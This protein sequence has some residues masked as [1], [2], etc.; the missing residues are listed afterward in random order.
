[1]KAYSKTQLEKKAEKHFKTFHEDSKA[2][3]TSDGYFFRSE[4]RAG[5]H[6]KTKKTLVVYIF[7]RKTE[8]SQID[9]GEAYKTVKDIEELVAQTEDAATLE[10]LL[11]AE[12]EGSNRKTAIAAIQARIDELKQK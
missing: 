3:A 6:A 9:T 11:I 10:E 12:Q 7:E 4:N 5:L 2:Y 8:A 1:M